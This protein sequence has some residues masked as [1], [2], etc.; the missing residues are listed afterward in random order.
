ME[1]WSTRLFKLTSLF[2]L[3]LTDT[4]VSLLNFSKKKKKKK[5][6]IS[7]IEESFSKETLM[8]LE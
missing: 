8:S 6:M 7:L 3:F 4:R 5:E 1:K 2:A